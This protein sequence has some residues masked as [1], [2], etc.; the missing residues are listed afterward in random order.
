[1]PT[2]LLSTPSNV[3]T[4][5]SSNIDVVE[6]EEELFIA[7]QK[8]TRNIAKKVKIVATKICDSIGT[9]VSLS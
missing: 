9:T 1:M 6:A 4:L 5:Y 8:L 7:D 3:S 2:G